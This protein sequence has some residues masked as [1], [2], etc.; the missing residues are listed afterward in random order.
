MAL[1]KEFTVSDLFMVKSRKNIFTFS[2]VS[3]SELVEDDVC[4]KLLGELAYF[5][6]QWKWIWVLTHSSSLT[7]KFLKKL[8]YQASRY[9]WN[10][11]H[12]FLHC[13]REIYSAGS[14]G[15]IVPTEC[16]NANFHVFLC[17]I[18]RVW[19]MLLLCKHLFFFHFFPCTTPECLSI[20]AV[21]VWNAVCKSNCFKVALR[22]RKTNIPLTFILIIS[23]IKIQGTKKSVY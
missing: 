1:V 8:S 22:G 23:V 10:M 14:V 21:R 6:Y 17:C 18:Q 16:G 13:G 2:D 19:V 12:H 3:L 11:Y 7:M 5:N 4:F 9:F 15:D 20:I